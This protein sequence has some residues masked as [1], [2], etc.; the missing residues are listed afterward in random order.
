MNFISF[1]IVIR[2]YKSYGN[3]PVHGLQE[4]NKA[5]RGELLRPKHPLQRQGDLPL[6]Q[7]HDGD[8]G[9]IF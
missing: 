8:Y 5:K 4:N 6:R 1:I 3:I 9:L 7:A 2:N